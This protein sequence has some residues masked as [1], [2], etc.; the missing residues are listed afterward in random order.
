MPL[1]MQYFIVLKLLRLEVTEFLYYFTYFSC[2][3]KK[4]NKTQKPKKP[5]GLGF[6][7]NVFLNPE[8]QWRVN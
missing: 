2:L 3:S 5:T 8:R 1:I 7:K 6:L 4:P